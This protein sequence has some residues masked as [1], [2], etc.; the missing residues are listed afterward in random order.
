MLL[1]KFL[2]VPTLVLLI[3]LVGRRWGP[4]VAGWMAGFP[5]VAGPTLLFIAVDQGTAFAA[6]AA[7]A[8]LISVLGNV[9]FLLAYA[10]AALRAPWYW[11]ATTGIA[12]F[13]LVAGVLG[14]LHAAPWIALITTLAGL[15][16]ASRAFPRVPFVSAARPSSAWELP[17]RCAAAGALALAVMQ[18]ADRLGPAASGLMAVFP[19][20]G[21][22][23]G[24]FSQWVWGGAGAARMLAGMLQ[25]LY[26][27][28]IFCFVLTIALAWTGTAPAF[29][30]AVVSALLMQLITFKRSA[31][32]M[33][34]MG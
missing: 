31:P 25:G 19:I 4:S 34:S 13:F 8:S 10:W 16:A 33:R 22:V 18:L 2:L 5:V 6:T 12:I 27:F 11:A 14:V 3:T 21:L 24:V 26:S 23:F 30:A 20:L 28:T 7:H 29:I 15:T 1:L 32:A 17:V 9:G